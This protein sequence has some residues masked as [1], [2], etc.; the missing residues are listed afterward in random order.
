MALLVSRE[1]AHLHLHRSVGP[2]Y[3]L[4]WLL[5]LALVSELYLLTC[6]VPLDLITCIVPLDLIINLVR[7]VGTAVLERA[8]SAHLYSSVGPNH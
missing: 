8:V 7:S 3:Y 1:S 2:N 5:P 4:T 6:I